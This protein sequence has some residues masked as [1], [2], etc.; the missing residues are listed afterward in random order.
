MTSRAIRRLKID[1]G[2]SWWPKMGILGDNGSR[3]SG[4]E[5]QLS[6]IFNNLAQGDS[7]SD[8]R[9]LAL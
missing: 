2:A 3:E 7:F 9:S 6:P 5:N 4:P 8:A 1:P